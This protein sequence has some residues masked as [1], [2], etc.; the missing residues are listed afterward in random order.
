MSLQHSKNLLEKINSLYQ[1]ITLDGHISAIERDLMLSYVRQFYEAILEESTEK[2]EPPKTV[3]TSAQKTVVEVPPVPTAA[4]VE[5]FVV[6]PPPTPVQEVIA[7]VVPPPPPPPVTVIEEKPVVVT[8]PK[9]APIYEAPAIQKPIAPPTP[10]PAAATKPLIKPT[11]ERVESDRLFEE[12]MSKELSDKLGEMP[13]D[14]IRKGMG[15]NERIIFLNELF[16][17]NASEFDNALNN[18]NN[19]VGFEQAKQL[20]MILSHRFDWSSKEKHA[21]PFIRLVKRKHS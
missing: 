13:I 6:T 7:P 16:D 11:T 2:Y 10:K 21:K 18:L 5:E 15:L 4:V 9:A 14:D 3:T 12:K 19:A 17:G 8:P 20:M 1:N